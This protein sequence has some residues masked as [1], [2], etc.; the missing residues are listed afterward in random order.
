MADT[1]T[2][3]L[4][5]EL[6]R[7]G[8][9]LRLDNAGGLKIYPATAVDPALLG[10]I[11]AHK[12]E[13]VAALE[14]AARSSPSSIA[15][16]PTL[17]R[18]E[19][20]DG[21]EPT[22]PQLA[23]LRA[24]SRFTLCESMRIDGA[25]DEGALRGSLAGLIA[26]QDALRARF[27][28]NGGAVRMH[29][30]PTVPDILRVISL[31]ADDPQALDQRV[32]AEIDTESRLPFDLQAGP[33][34]RALLMRISP[35]RHV[36][37]LS[38]HHLVADAWSF[39]VIKSDMAAFYEA[40]L[41]GSCAEPEPLRIGYGDFVHWQ[42]QLRATHELDRQ[43]AYW[44][45][46]LASFA[47]QASFPIGPE[48]T[49]DST[50][51]TR[52]LKFDPTAERLL[53]LKSFAALKGTTPYVVLVAAVQLALAQYS[54]LERQIVWTPIS[55]RTQVEL[56]KSVGLY[57]NLIAIVGR[58]EGHLTLNEFL[59]GIERKVLRAHE[60][61]DVSALTA[62]MKN[63]ALRPNMPVVGL[64]VIDS[65]TLGGGWEFAGTTVT[66]IEAHRQDEAPVAALEVW[67]PVALDAMITVAYDTT[68]FSADAVK[69]IVT[70]MLGAV[71]ALTGNS[72]SRLADVVKFPHKTQ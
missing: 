71:D 30:R 53:R 19:L 68:I 61:G 47:G 60:N 16:R 41:Q 26:R 33:L 4:F 54:G 23:M 72:Q 55:R 20:V 31:D 58:V 12:R 9:R 56:E 6:G 11:R 52:R 37:V 32:A 17:K 57:T 59:T 46:E 10:E 34:I 3:L 25:L 42:G 69:R 65:S 64:N 66:S 38:V 29:V 13:I 39:N 62:V 22:Y 18:V 8:L 48:S 35:V 28:V 14:A 49:G 43:L 44:G 5:Q 50:V 40:E 27:V 70:G 7:R 63:P 36:L 67:L 24:P 51:L 21:V 2:A 45:N 15:E 1:T